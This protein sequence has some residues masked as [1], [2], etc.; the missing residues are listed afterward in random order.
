MVPDWVDDDNSGAESDEVRN[1]SDVVCGRVKLQ[2]RWVTK[3]IYRP[4]IVKSYNNFMGGEDLSDQMTAVN[5]SKKQKRWYLRIF[6]NMV[7]LSIYNAYIL[8]EFKR[9]QTPRRRRKRDLLSFKEDLCVQLVG[10]F[11]QQHKSTASNK[12]KECRHTSA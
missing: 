9:P 6:L 5:K 11:P 3:K 10:N 7:L 1:E 8:E 2:G 4:G 12:R